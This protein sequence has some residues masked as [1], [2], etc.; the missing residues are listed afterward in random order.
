MSKL[1]VYRAILVMVTA[2]N[3]LCAV[4]LAPVTLMA[5][6]MFDNPGN[7]QRWWVWALVIFFFFLILSIPLWFVAGAVLGWVLHLR[8][9]WMLGSLLVAAAPLV[10]FPLLFIYAF[11]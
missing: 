9:G 10:A 7:E 6:M 4:V 2:A 8:R 1:H 5:F 3:L 11:E